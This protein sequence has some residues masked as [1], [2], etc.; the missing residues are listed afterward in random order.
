MMVSRWTAAERAACRFAWP[1]ARLAAPLPSTNRPA[2]TDLPFAAA[3]AQRGAAACGSVAPTVHSL[4]RLSAMTQRHAGRGGRERRHNDTTHR[5]ALQTTANSCRGD[6]RIQ[7][8]AM[9]RECPNA[10]TASPPQAQ[11]FRCAAVSL[12]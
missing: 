9:A 3:A 7:E 4:H 5:V 12:P 10:A 11:R 6:G 1:P 2:G 8:T